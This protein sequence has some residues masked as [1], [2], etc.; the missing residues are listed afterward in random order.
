MSNA[1]LYLANQN[2]QSVPVNGAIN[3]GNV[4]RRYGSNISSLGG[5]AVLK[6]N[7]Y[8]MVTANITF[9]DTAAGTATVT[10][11]ADG[12]PIPGATA[13]I[14]TGTANA[15][16]TETIPAVVRVT[17]CK[18]TVITAVVTGVEIDVTNAGLVAE[19]L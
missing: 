14:T 11:L 18:S 6:G 16:H 5:N 15:A 7:G 13:T 10:L 8:Y 9:T 2:E 3:F 19:K 4:I 17:C 1:V 12:V